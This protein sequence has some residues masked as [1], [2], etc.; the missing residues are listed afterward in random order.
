[1]TSGV[2]PL[3][4]VSQHAGGEFVSEFGAVFAILPGSLTR[5]LAQVMRQ[6]ELFFGFD[7]DAE[8]G[9]HGGA[10]SVL[11]ARPITRSTSA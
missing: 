9:W 10:I 5:R 3:V 4:R 1:M 11:Q 6:L 7:V 2:T 8:W